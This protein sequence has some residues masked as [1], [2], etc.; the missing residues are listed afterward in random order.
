[1]L[2]LVVLVGK[3]PLNFATIYS[4]LF[5][6]SHPTTLISYGDLLVVVT[7]SFL[8]A[9]TYTVISFILLHSFMSVN[10]FPAYSLKA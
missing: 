5:A 4:L 8:L 2:F 3:S 10:V 9:F 7:P 1:M 6:I